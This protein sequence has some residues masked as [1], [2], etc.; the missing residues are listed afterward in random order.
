MDLI[1]GIDLTKDSGVLLH[2]HL[3]KVFKKHGITPEDF[4]GRFPNAVLEQQEIEWNEKRY[5][6]WIRSSFEG[7]TLIAEFTIKLDPQRMFN[8]V[9]E[10][11]K[12]WEY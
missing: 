2:L 10:V 7:G 9:L 11:G 12:E 4:L 5:K 8:A 6:V 1:P 3:E